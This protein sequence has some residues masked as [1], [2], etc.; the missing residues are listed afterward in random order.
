MPEGDAERIRNHICD[1]VG[2][3]RLRGETT[4]AIRVG[5]I[6][7]DLILL[8][9]NAALDICQVLD[10]DIFKDEA[11]VEYTRK[12]GPNQGIST[13]YHFRILF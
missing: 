5:D 6:R 2:R 7:D 1:L 8:Y 13:I 3:A 10:T 9:D 4:I 12:I 11:R